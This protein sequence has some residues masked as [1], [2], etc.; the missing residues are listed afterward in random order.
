MSRR[1]QERWKKG[2]PMELKELIHEMDVI[3]F[4]ADLSADSGHVDEARKNLRKAKEL[5]DDEFL[6]D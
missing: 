5:L 2:K 3:I 4:E 6:N 1:L